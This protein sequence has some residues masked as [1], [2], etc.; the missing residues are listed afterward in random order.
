MIGGHRTNE[1]DTLARR[2]SDAES[3]ARDAF[4]NMISDASFSNAG[5]FTASMCTWRNAHN[6]AAAIAEELARLKNRMVP[7]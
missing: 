3:F 1:V 5:T 2:L 6:K 7:V 4:Q